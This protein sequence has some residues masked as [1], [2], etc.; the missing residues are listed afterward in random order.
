MDLHVYRVIPH[1]ST[2]KDINYYEVEI[3]ELKQQV[4]PDRGPATLV[5]YDG[6][7]PGPT[8]QM[9]RGT[10]AVV[11]FINKSKKPNS[12]HLHGSYSVCKTPLFLDR[13]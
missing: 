6:L 12:V 2:G 11:R 7:S 5:G 3:K 1:P 10:E 4:Y 8:F 13:G 9:Q